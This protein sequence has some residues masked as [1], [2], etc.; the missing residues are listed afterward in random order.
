MS[1]FRSQWITAVANVHKTSTANVEVWWRWGLTDLID[2]DVSASGWFDWS[3]D[4]CSNSPDTGTSFDFKA[5]CARH[6]D[7]WRN[8]QRLDKN[9]N[10]RGSAKN[11]PCGT[12]GLSTGTLGRYWTKDNRLKANEQFY[13]DMVDHCNGR[14]FT[15][16]P[17]CRSRALLYK[18]AVDRFA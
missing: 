16:R 17:S 11:K 18:A 8:L 6:D 3:S 4:F 12:N 5:P 15:L 7:G 1:D 13:R 2:G 14:S 10:C 9:W